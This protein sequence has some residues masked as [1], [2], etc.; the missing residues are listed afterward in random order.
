MTGILIIEKYT[1]PFGEAVVK[2]HYF[3]DV[4]NSELEILRDL[5]GKSYSVNVDTRGTVTSIIQVVKSRI[6]K[7]RSEHIEYEYENV[8]IRDPE[9][10]GWFQSFI[11]G[12]NI[13]DNGWVQ[14]EPP[15]SYV[16]Y[17]ETSY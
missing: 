3:G 12:R 6:I 2:R 9:V 1:D 13:F 16:G 5:S 14:P 10:T 15:I 8:D 17:I 7:V 4:S 11:T